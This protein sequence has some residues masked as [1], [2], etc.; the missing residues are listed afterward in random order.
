MKIHDLSGSFETDDASQLA[1]RLR[2][3]RV[4]GYGA[5]HVSRN[6]DLPYI[7]AHFNGDIAYIHYFIADD[8]PGFHPTD[9]S[10]P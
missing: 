6:D 5:F 3:V 9:I 2:S 4:E 10:P 8:H 1:H 7:S